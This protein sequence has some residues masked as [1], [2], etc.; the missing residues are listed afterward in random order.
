MATEEVGIAT[1]KRLKAKRMLIHDDGKCLNGQKYTLLVDGYCPA[2]GFV[3][4]MQ[5]IAIIFHCPTHNAELDKDRK[6]PV[7]KKTFDTRR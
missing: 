6:C 7:C 2:C 1:M 4:D 5:S 3:P